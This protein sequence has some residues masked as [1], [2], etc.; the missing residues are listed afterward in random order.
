MQMTY[1]GVPSERLVGTSAKDGLP[2]SRWLTVI[3]DERG[4]LKIEFYRGLAFLHASF[5]RRFDAMRAARRYFPQI[6]EWLRRMG[7]FFVYV[8]IPD[9]DEALLRF[10]KHF[11]FQE[12]RHLNG[13][14][15]LA[16]RCMTETQHG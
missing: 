1:T 11:G 16:Q 13:H 6:K 12:I 7:H 5:R 2:R 9:D 8:A 10:E 3:D 4:T 14:I 15:I